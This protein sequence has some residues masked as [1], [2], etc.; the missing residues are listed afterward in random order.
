MIKWA[1]VGWS[2]PGDYPFVYTKADF[3]TVWR[4][5]TNNVI[6]TGLGVVANGPRYLIFREPD[7]PAKTPWR[8]SL[9]NT[10]RGDFAE[11]PE[12]AMVKAEL[13]EHERTGGK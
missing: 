13:M 12:A 11:T 9:V 2:K 7:A 10:L 1:W 6:F 4:S 5:H 8:V 3:A